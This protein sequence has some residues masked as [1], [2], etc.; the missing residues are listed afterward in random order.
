MT[1]IRQ[2]LS[3]LNFGNQL[4]P[5]GRTRI[6]NQLL[7]GDYKQHND[8][9]GGSYNTETI[10]A[11]AFSYEN[12]AVGATELQVSAN[13][14]ACIRQTYQWHN[15]FAGK[16]TK[17]ELTASYFQPQTDVIKRMGYFS[18]T[19]TTPFD[20]NKD[21]IYFES[22]GGT[23]SCKVDRNGTNVF[24]LAQTNWLN[25]PELGS[26]DPSAFNFYVIDFL[27]LGGAI[28]NFW[29][30]TEYG[31]VKIASYQHIN[32]D[33]N[34]FIKSP[35]QPVRYEIR[36]TGGAGVFNHICS[37]VVSEG[38][39]QGVGTIKSFSNGGD[40]VS[41]NSV[42]V[43]YA[44]L[45]VRHKALNRNVIFDFKSISILASSADD[46]LVEFYFGGTIVG[47]PVWNDITF[48]YAQ[49]FNAGD[50]GTV[51]DRVHS[52][53][54]LLSSRYIRGGNADN[55]ILQTS[56]RLGSYINGTLEEAYIC[57]TPLT[58]NANAAVSLD[59]TEF[60]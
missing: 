52:G 20:A 40:T 55:Q 58:S 46:L 15:Y 5:D 17:V 10:G 8:I 2:T 36:S 4:S 14:D 27:Y 1:L 21:G 60:I 51:A 37:D 28:V 19:T 16:P 32:V 26:F 50:I 11:G 22:S 9:A 12:S 59:W 30:L 31:L 43:R 42:G 34:T 45:G 56:R 7:Q 29:V 48:S 35:N 18:S 38:F 33:Q 57:V 13:L 54:V 39:D 25:Q 6:S 3:N 23:I 41:V 47:T 49:G 53:G 44:L 24:S